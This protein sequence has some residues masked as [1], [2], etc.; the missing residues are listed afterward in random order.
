MVRGIILA[1]GKGTRLYPLTLGFSKH[2]LPIY[3]KPMIYYPLSV[4]MLAEIREI[5]IICTPGSLHQYQNVLSTGSQWGI[6][7][8]YAEQKHPNGIPEAFLIAENFIKEESVCLILGDNFFYGDEFP[9]ILKTGL[10]L[11]KG[12]LI[13]GYPVEDPERFG[14]VE[15]DEKF[16]VQSLEEKP[17]M[18]KSKYAITGLYFY[19]KN[20]V[21]FAKKLNPSSRGELEI[22]DLNQIYLSRNELNF[23]PLERRLLWRDVGTVESLFAIGQFV[24]TI[25][26]MEGLKIGCLE[27]IALNKKWISPEAV[28]C[29]LDKFKNSSYREYLESILNLN[30]LN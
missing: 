13:F 27:E 26:K 7:I 23:I 14:I 4:L 10:N 15:F 20:V 1:G 21:N 6:K 12:A 8:E 5:L 24:K 19:D 2:L 17:V 30:I 25:E 9:E 28:M 29:S 11:K 22:T 16:R 18:P 3:D